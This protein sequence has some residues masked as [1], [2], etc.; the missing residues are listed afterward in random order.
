L[1]RSKLFS[2]YDI[3]VVFCTLVTIMLVGTAL[4]GAAPNVDVLIVG[5]VFTGVG[6][7]GVVIGVNQLFATLALEKERPQLSGYI[8]L[9]WCLGAL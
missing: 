8:G 5:R 4:A 7:S 6:A 3:K 9:G 1:Q 2:R